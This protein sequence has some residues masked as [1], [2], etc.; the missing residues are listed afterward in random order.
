MVAAIKAGYK[1]RLSLNLIASVALTCQILFISPRNSQEG[2]I[3]LF[4]KTDCHTILFPKSH[5]NTVQPWLQERDM[6]PI[7]VGEMDKWF[8]EKRVPHFPYSK[9][10]EEAEWDPV[11]VLH[12]SGSTG[13]PKPI[14][15]CVGML[16][17]GDSFN[18]E[19]AFQGSD[20]IFNA[21]AK[22]SKRNFF[23]SM[24]QAT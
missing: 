1:V 2:Q 5:H 24:S 13:F 7:E 17:I 19:P 16:S 18:K 21:W 22:K 15:A 6:K 14:V 4:D 10:Y 11:V 8:P 12:T 3:N 9:T 20:F 23:P